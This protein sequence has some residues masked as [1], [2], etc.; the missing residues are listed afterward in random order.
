MGRKKYKLWSSLRG[1][2][3][4][5][6]AMVMP[7]AEIQSWER[8]PIANWYLSMKI[9]SDINQQAICLCSVVYLMESKIYIAFQLISLAVL[10]KNSFLDYP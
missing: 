10:N 5:I 2:G 4:Q 9:C 8:V 1:S 7:P 3:G 6:S